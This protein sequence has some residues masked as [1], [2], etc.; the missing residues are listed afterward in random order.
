MEVISF[1]CWSCKQVLRIGAD[2][3]GRK[4]KCTKCG[5]ELTIPAVS[6]DGETPTPAPEPKPYVYQ[7]EDG[8][9]TYGVIKEAEPAPEE[10][11]KARK[12]DDEE[13]QTGGRSAADRARSRKALRKAPVNPE[14]W[15]KVRLGMMLAVIA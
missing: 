4:A 13:R 14:Q 9:G 8:G 10:K 1:R 15:E 7:E 3:A 2:K 6:A 5:T 11:P 12:E